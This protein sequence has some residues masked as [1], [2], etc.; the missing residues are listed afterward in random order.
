[1]RNDGHL[2]V[3]QVKFSTN[4]QGDTDPLTWEKLL[5]EPPGKSGRARMSLLQKWATSFRDLRTNDQSVVASVVSNRTA[6]LGLQASLTKTT[7]LVDF[8]RIPDNAVRSEVARQL[9]DAVAARLFFSEFRFSLDEPSLEDLESLLRR[10]FDRLGGNETGWLNLHN[11][12]RFWVSHRYEPAPDGA[13][14]LSDVMRAARWHA[15]QSL[16][17]RFSVPNDY[18]LPSEKFHGD[19]HSN[20][21]SAS[22]G[23]VVITA[24]PGVGKSTYTSY[25]YNHLKENDTPVIRHH[26]YLSQDDQM[27]VIRL[28]HLRAAESLMFDL[29]HEHA[30][31]LG[32]HAAENPHG[33]RLR[34]WL[35]ACGNF[36]AK[37]GKRLIVVVD[38]L[39]H[40]WRDTR[41]V[42]E[43]AKLLKFVLPAPEGVVVLL[44]TQPVDDSQLPP[45]LLKY[46]PR[47]NWRRLPLMDQQAVITWLR[48]HESELKGTASAKESSEVNLP[49]YKFQ[50][51]GEALYE[52]SVTS[53]S[54]WRTLQGCRDAHMMTSPSTTESYGA[55]CP[56]RA[57]EFC[58]YLP[59]IAFRGASAVFSS[60]SIPTA[61]GTRLLTTTLGRLNTY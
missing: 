2:V 43:L 7:G 36:Y 56:S 50:R 10:R 18:V 44:A 38:G 39:D 32:T 24:S 41:S 49:D 21:L 55:F 13:I 58:T 61:P 52:K 14:K 42:E 6:G 48:H 19:L 34:E 25:L 23:C 16:P 12:V 60:A 1:M 47:D 51:L 9:G 46:A 45:I 54:L 30:D 53:L 11:E 17:Q 26:Y 31:A 33:S 20:L 22:S 27:G 28:D 4:P 37:H 57:A 40:V 3:K 29:S 59:P 5:S 15:L 35:V 8:D